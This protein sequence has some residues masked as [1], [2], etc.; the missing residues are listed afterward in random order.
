MKIDTKYSIPNKV[1]FLKDDAV[2]Q[3]VIIGVNVSVL[4]DEYGDISEYMYYDIKCTNKTYN[5][6]SEKSIFKTKQELLD[7]L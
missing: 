6:I 2:H 1:Y 7:S 5:H 4:S 3:G